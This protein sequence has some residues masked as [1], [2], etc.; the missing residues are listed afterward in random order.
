MQRLFKI[1]KRLSSQ[2]CLH[3]QFPGM[4]NRLMLVNLMFCVCS[5]VV[6]AKVVTPL[7]L[8]VIYIERQTDRQRQRK[9]ETE[10]EIKRDAHTKKKS[11]IYF[12]RNYLIQRIH[13][14]HWIEQVFSNKT[15]FLH[16]IA[17]TGYVFFLVIRTQS[18]GAAEYTNCISAEGQDSPNEYPG[19]D[20]KQSDNEATVMLKLWGMWSTPS[21]LSLPVLLFGSFLSMGQIE[22]FDI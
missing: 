16:I 8:K 3:R 15:L 12:Q 11:L 1:H 13:L 5:I 21:L 6:T 4:P 17:T 9:T 14:Q 7:N 2:I 19:Y 20:I 22:L 18:A 10:T